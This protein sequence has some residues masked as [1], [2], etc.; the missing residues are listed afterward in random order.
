MRVSVCGTGYYC[1][2]GERGEPGQVGN[3]GPSGLKGVH[4]RKGEFL[5]ID[6]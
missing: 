6:I 4:G 5:Y 3:S 1:L 2:P